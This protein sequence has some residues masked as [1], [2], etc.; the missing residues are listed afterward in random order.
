MK[1]LVSDDH[2]LIRDGVTALLERLEPGADI[3]QATTG[4]EA[5]ATAAEHQDLDLAVIDLS[6]PGTSGLP[7]VSRLCE[8]LADTPVLVLSASADRHLVL[9]T[10]ECGASGFIYKALGNAALEEALRMVLAGGVFMP[11]VRESE[12]DALSTVT[13]R[14]R[15]ILELLA[16]GKS[17]KEIANTLHISANTIKNHLAKLYEHFRVSNRTQAVMKAQEMIS[18]L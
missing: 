16:Q 6:L 18:D 2:E 7:M 1:I 14:Q 10:I 8:L 4:D 3:F 12:D 15:Q 17:N 11:P 5:I 9:K 13:P